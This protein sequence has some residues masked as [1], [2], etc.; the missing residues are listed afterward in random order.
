VEVVDRYYA[1]AARSPAEA[2]ALLV[3]PGLA[4]RLGTR[5]PM[6]FGDGSD[7]HAGTGWIVIGIGDRR[8][9]VLS[10]RGS[11]GR[12]RITAVEPERATTAR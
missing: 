1:R 4:R 6:A 9:R 2:R 11:D 10:R 7:P 3:D 5:V 8:S 12:W